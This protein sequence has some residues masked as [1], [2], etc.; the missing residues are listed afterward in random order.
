MAGRANETVRLLYHARA[1]LISSVGIVGLG[2]GITLTRGDIGQDVLGSFAMPLLAATLAVLAFFAW[3][4]WIDYVSATSLAIDAKGASIGGRVIPWSAVRGV[5][6]ATGAFRLALITEAGKARFQ[7]LVLP[8]PIAALKLLV[9]EAASAGAKVEP[10]L[11]QLA[12]HV[13]EDLD[14]DTIEP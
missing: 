3:L 6:R 11:R 2:V 5:T 14:D 12:E 7:L 13:D 9:S 8:R 10:Y 1:L 4:G